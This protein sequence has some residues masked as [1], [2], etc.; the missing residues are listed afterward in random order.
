MQ[1]CGTVLDRS[2]GE[3]GLLPKPSVQ[4]LAI[5]S[6][7]HPVTDVGIISNDDIHRPSGPS[8]GGLIRPLDTSNKTGITM[9]RGA[10]YLLIASTVFLVGSYAIHFWLARKLG[11]EDY[12]AYGVV[13]TLMSTANLLVTTGFPQGASKYIAEGGSNHK[14]VVRISTRIQVMV[15][16]IVFAL[17]FG[18][19]S[20]IAGLL[21]DPRLTVYIRISA[22]V[23]PAYALFS[24]YSDGY[25]N[26]LRYFA[27]QAKASI[28]NSI[29]K[30]VLVFMLVL[31]GLSVKGAILGYLG[32]ALLGWLFAWRYL[33]QVEGEASHFQWRKLLS[34]GIPATLF[35]VALFL[36]MSIDL[37]AVKAIMRND[38]ST[39]LYTSAT[40]IA[41]V[42]YY[43]FGGLATALLPSISRSTSMNQHTVTANYI[44]QS[45]RYMLM[46]LVPAVLIVSAT[47]HS[48]V[49]LLYSPTYSQAA[50]PLG[51][52]T[53]GL[54]FLAVFF[55]LAYIIMGSG[56]PGIAL[57]IVLPL[58]MVD[59]VLNIF[60][61]RRYGLVGAAWAT[62]ITGLI[63]MIVAGAYVLKR[64]NTLVN[65][66]SLIRICLASLA[67]Y[68]IALL[69]PFTTLFLPLI[70]VGLVSVY[71]GLL[72]LTRELRRDDLETM[73]RI[74]PFAGFDRTGHQTN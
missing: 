10:L 36:I 61:I 51:V 35:S 8:H 44:S 15:S 69:I 43:L 38:T 28:A 14:T 47:S 32:A 37:F 55:V 29:G 52:L 46:L 3:L 34:F 1:Y 71:F 24:L 41:K 54:A 33:G 25:L 16:L 62:T 50:N 58:L 9:A 21:N 67:V 39:G 64:F 68:G 60:L 70:Y 5:Q 65:P 59:I 13:L 4:C 17:Y 19:S 40:T 2:Y 57:G 6:C 12:G 26:G 74:L 30:V 45:M 66:K 27:E 56:R 72:L 20:V 48:L 49:S 53:I 23:V 22:F 18:L 42:P 73:K 63:S 31:I 11:P 7:M